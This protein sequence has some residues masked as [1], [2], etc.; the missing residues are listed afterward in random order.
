VRTDELAAPE[1]IDVE[2]MGLIRRDTCVGALHDSRSEIA[3][4]ELHDWAGVRFAHRA[5][6]DRVWELRAN[7]RT[8]DAYY[9][10]LADAL[11]APLVT[12]DRRL[13]R[14]TGPV[15]RFIVPDARVDEMT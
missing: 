14:A 9:V 11:D 12:L 2:V 3:V 6:S 8:W 1:L 13:A 5:F 15:C 4:A 10:A 7:V